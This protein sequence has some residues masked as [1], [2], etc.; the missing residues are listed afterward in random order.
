MW[1]YVFA[2][3]TETDAERGCKRYMI[4]LLY[5]LGSLLQC[6]V[7]A[8][9]VR[10]HCRRYKVTALPVAL[11]LLLLLLPPRTHTVG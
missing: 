1:K 3:R 5:M 11:L 2:K 4:P 7:V 8:V 6:E 10:G 9:A